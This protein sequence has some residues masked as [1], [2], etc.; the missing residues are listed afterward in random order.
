[1]RWKEMQNEVKR[2]ELPGARGRERE[3]ETLC[4]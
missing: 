1:M 2:T 3:T 4:L